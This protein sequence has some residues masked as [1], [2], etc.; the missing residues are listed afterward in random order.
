MNYR[1]ENQSKIYWNFTREDANK[2]L[3]KY[4]VW[5]EKVKIKLSWQ[6]II[7]LNKFRL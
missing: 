7:I 6:Y 3:S 2:K 5:N 4:Y 1:N